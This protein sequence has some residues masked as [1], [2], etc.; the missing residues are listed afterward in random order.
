MNNKLKLR[1]FLY[2]WGVLASEWSREIKLS[3]RSIIYF[4]YGHGLGFVHAFA[5]FAE[6]KRERENERNVED[7]PAKR[8]SPMFANFPLPVQKS[9]Q[10]TQLKHKLILQI[11]Q[12]SWQQWQ[13]TS[14]ILCSRHAWKLHYSYIDWDLP[15]SHRSP[16]I[17]KCL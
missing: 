11:R 15:T 9:R 6:G 2:G 4:E 14:F 12:P 13:Q 3:S 8:S 1:S 16:F 10:H 7:A 17:H 5:D